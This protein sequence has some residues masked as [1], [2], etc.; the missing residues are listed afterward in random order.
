MQIPSDYK[1]LLRGLNA[2]K[3]R[4]LIVGAY[5]VIHY[6]EPR[7][8]KDIDIWVEPDMENAKKLYEALKEFGAPLKGVSVEDFM[9]KNLVYQMG[10]VPVRV[11]IIMAVG[12][13]EF[14]QAW[15]NRKTIA[16]NGEKANL[17][18]VEELIKS[19]KKAK[20][21]IDLIDVENL[22]LKLRLQ[23]GRSK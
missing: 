14:K 16:L 19:K 17:I 10:V 23:K 3:V 12:D 20:R 11:D 9:N 1:E 18:G 5:A 7:Y 2:H 6:T 13:L 15:N 21:K 4:Y 22:Q 8:T